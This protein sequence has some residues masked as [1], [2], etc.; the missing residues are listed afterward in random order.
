MANLTET[1]YSKSTANTISDFPAIH[2]RQKLLI[3]LV[4]ILFAAARLFRLDSN[5]LWFDEIFS[6]HAAEHSWARLM[7]FVAA[8]LVHPPLF[9]LLLKLWIG[10]GGESLLW[11]R[12]FPAITSLIAMVPIVLLARELKLS[13]SETTLALLLLA[14]NGY[15]IKY[16]QEVRM[17]SLFFF[18]SA[19]SLWLFVSLAQGKAGFSRRL[20]ALTVVNLLMIYTHYYGWL[21]VAAQ[22]V[23]IVRLERRRVRQFIVSSTVLVLCYLP[24][25]MQ[26]ARAFEAN[27]VGQNIG[28]IPRPG[29]R[30]FVEWVTLLNQPFT[31]QISNAETGPNYFIVVMVMLVF[32]FP[33]ALFLGSII[34]RRSTADWQA[35]VFLAVFAFAPA[36]S[37]AALS[38]LLPRSIWGTRHLIIA[39]V[40]YL[41]LAAIAIARLRLYWVRIA[42]SLLL[43]CWVLMAGAYALIRP[44]PSFIWCAWT[45]LAHQL[46]EVTPP[47]SQAVAVYAFEDL[48]AYHLWFALRDSKSVKYRVGVIKSAPGIADD[49]AYFLP[50]DFN[51]VPARGAGAPIED[52]LWIA[53]RGARLDLHAQPLQQFVGGG[54]ELGTVFTQHADGQDAFLVELHKKIGA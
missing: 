23:M 9:Y 10:I 11:L 28:W 41:M 30:A 36:V 50:R 44:A 22:L 34:K 13:R 1:I 7:H 52:E 3:T 2:L 12:L 21:V 53:F 54:Y 19:C 20:V 42:V 45:P 51:E 4:I 39:V 26:I 8:D 27:R 46:M 31:V 47:P 33:L 29:I 24:W 17:Y 6:V 37:A 48:V 15:S 43:S 32:I 40:P 14:V 18:L 25:L 35:L 5:C 38:W 16:A 49:P